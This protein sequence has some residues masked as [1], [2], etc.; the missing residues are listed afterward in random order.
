MKFFLGVGR[1]PRNN[2]SDFGG[3]PDSLPSSPVLPQFCATV[4]HFQ[5]DSNSLLLY[6]PGGR[7]S[8]GGVIRST[9]LYNDT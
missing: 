6:S 2:R 5:W 1:A 4:I 7:T 8:L 9:D 3:D